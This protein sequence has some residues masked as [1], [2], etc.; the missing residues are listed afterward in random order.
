MCYYLFMNYYDEILSKIEDLINKN[1]YDEAKSLL[2]AE[3]K[4]PYIPK[5]IEQKLNEFLEL[6]KEK[7]FIIKSLSDEEIIEYLKS[8][9]TKQL[10]AIKELNNKNLRD[11]ID[12]CED[13]L[14]TNGHKEAKVLLIESLIRQ[15]INYK[16][17]Y[18]NITFNPKD[19]LSP[20]NSEGF[21]KGYEILNDFYL[22]DPSKL[23]MAIQLLYKECILYL[24]NSYNIE[25]GEQLSQKI[26]NYIEKAFEC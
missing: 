6:I 25:Q 1:E 10:I 3:L 8:D 13:Y 17:I 20:E 9:N 12:I 19:C 11:Y 7:T 16:F 2:L 26:I 5:E 15:E 24:P 4:V 22:K 21:L 14:K 18:E 23:Q